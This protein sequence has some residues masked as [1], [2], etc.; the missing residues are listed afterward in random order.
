MPVFSKDAET[1]ARA[2]KYHPC[3]LYIPKRTFRSE[4]HGRQD[5]SATEDSRCKGVCR[6][7]PLKIDVS[8][9]KPQANRSPTSL[10]Q[11]NRG[12]LNRVLFRKQGGGSYRLSKCLQQDHS[13]GTGGGGAL[14]LE[15]RLKGPKRHQT[16]CMC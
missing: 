6:Q 1:N 2:P 10:T 9:L 14:A 16:K 15:S 11:Q 13:R 8:E 4:H 7:K 5:S 12:I 3:F